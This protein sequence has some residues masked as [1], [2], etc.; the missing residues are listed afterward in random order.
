MEELL[1]HRK[2]LLRLCQPLKL[3]E[4]VK[5]DQV[6]GL[7]KL[8]KA[9]SQF[10]DTQ[11]LIGSIGEWLGKAK[12]YVEAEKKRRSESFGR[13]VGEFIRA[14]REIGVTVREFSLSQWRVGPFEIKFRP[15]QSQV[16]YFYN[17][18]ILQTWAN[19][20]TAQDL[21]K[22]TAKME[23]KLKTNVLPADTFRHTLLEAH[24]YL[25][26]K[27]EKSGVMNFR[28]VLAGELVKETKVVLYRKWLEKKLP[29]LNDDSLWVFLYNLDLYFAHLEQ[30]PPSERLSRETG[31]QHEI[32]QGK[33][34]VLN[35]LEA[36][37]DYKIVCYLK[38]YA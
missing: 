19:V 25:Q 27:Q 17:Q 9:I 28:S 7:D 21:S 18:E 15:T 32:R 38:S 14:Q 36:N 23:N 16:A 33:G 30:V 8:E 22:L 24:Q 2:E 10:P 3:I 13:V 34:I 12:L 26:E 1:K 6:D 20:T 11:T 31:S 5:L 37:E 35:G 4:K 29:K